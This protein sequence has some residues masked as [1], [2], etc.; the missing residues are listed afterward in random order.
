MIGGV[1]E[2]SIKIGGML[3]MKKR[4]DVLS[5]MIVKGCSLINRE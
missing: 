3:E 5:G 4:R 1:V 2:G